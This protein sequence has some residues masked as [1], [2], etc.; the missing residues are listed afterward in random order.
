MQPKTSTALGCFGDLKITRLYLKYLIPHST[1][2]IYHLIAII[3]TIDNMVVI[4]D[5]SS[6]DLIFNNPVFAL[7]ITRTH[8]QIMIRD[9]MLV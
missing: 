1:V 7:I 8:K 3:K 5:M 9:T 4:L 6:N 2:V